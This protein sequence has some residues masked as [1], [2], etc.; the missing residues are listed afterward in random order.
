MQLKKRD[1]NLVPILVAIVALIGL[2]TWYH[3]LGDYTIQKV[4][5]ALGVD[6]SLKI[7]DLVIE[8]GFN[9]I[10]GLKSPEVKISYSTSRLADSY[11]KVNDVISESIVGNKFSKTI[12]L[13]RDYFGKTIEVV[14]YAKDSEGKTA[15]IT[16]DIELPSNIEP[17]IAIINT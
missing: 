2:A 4:D 16:R 6:T 5:A 10:G 14:I 17:I 3:F 8:K 15:E 7:N 1:D 9:E 12:V 11:I 13:N